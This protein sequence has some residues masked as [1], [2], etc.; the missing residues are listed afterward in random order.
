MT[1]RVRA[2]LMLMAALAM[3]GLAGCDHYVCGNGNPILS[4]SC[5]ASGTGIGG[6]GTNT[7]LTAF[8][9]VYGGTGEI[10]GIALDGLNVAD[11]GT[12]APIPTFVSPTFPEQYEASAMVTVDKQFL[13]MPLSNDTILG[14]SIDSSSGALTPLST[15]PFPVTAPYS[16]AVDPTGRFLFVGGS[17]G[18]S[19]FTVNATTGEL[20]ETS[21]SPFSTGGEF[22]FQMATDGK[23]RY[24]YA[25]QGAGGGNLLEFSYDQTTGALTSLGTLSS[26][27]S[28]I[29]GE[30]SGQYILGI[31]QEAG[32]LDGPTDPHI[33][34]FGISATG[35]ITEL[36]AS[37]FP[38]TNDPVNIAVS[39]NGAFVYAFTASPFESGTAT[40]PVE[41]YQLSAL[42]SALTPLS[43]SPF[44]SLLTE[45][46]M[47][48]QSG[49]YLFVGGTAYAANTTTGAL[50]SSLPGYGFGETIWAVTDA[51]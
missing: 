22:V 9:Y 36:A 32:N 13:Y 3:L 19:V 46:G 31:T 41:G 51:P 29:A 2:S 14:F 21:G 35:T 8:E 23:G 50:T 42:P 27:V 48:D 40:E 25:V 44:T 30:S 47:F 1:M 38:T 10:Q 34:V 18:I 11:S 49:Q 12:F 15:S 7:G 16:M 37:P 43:T 4:G 17:A 6:G 39:P 45:I 33:Y 26:K 20:T 5:T 28:E 24:L